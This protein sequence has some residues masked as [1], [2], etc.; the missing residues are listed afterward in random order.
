MPTA[1]MRYQV[2]ET[3]DVA[4][5]LDRAAEW[6]PGEPRSKLLLRLLRVGYDTLEQR[7]QQDIGVHRAAVM[8]TSGAYPGAFGPS[9]LTELREDW[10][11]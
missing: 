11:A 7:D 4:R 8:A 5:A 3:E 9:Y 1:R 6:W 10:P 2:T